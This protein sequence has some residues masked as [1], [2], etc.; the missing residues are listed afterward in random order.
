MSTCLPWWRRETCAPG[1][2]LALGLQT[3]ARGAAH[4][5][6]SGSSRTAAQHGSRD[7][8]RQCRVARARRLHSC[9]RG[10]AA[11]G[12]GRP[13]PQSSG[14]GSG[15]ADSGQGRRSPHLEASALGHLLQLGSRA[16]LGC[17][18]EAG[19]DVHLRHALRPCTAARHASALPAD[20]SR[21]AGRHGL[22]QG[23]PAASLGAEAVQQSVSSTV[24]LYNLVRVGGSGGGTCGSDQ[25][26]DLVLPAV[27][28]R[29]GGGS[30]STFCSFRA[31]IFILFA[32]IGFLQLMY[33]PSVTQ[34]S[35]VRTA[36]LKS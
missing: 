8:S 9:A 16:R 1:Q 22:Q 19:Q 32:Q 31:V 13:S 11:G 14:C 35:H 28:R 23:R 34:P 33:K 2:P 21:L 27:L 15:R 29:Q 17:H 20:A 3:P 24:M 30:R 26:D 36:P 25:V 10:E 4:P 5:P 12:G 7:G 6:R 18:T